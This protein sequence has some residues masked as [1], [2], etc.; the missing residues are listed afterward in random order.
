MIR[1]QIRV[2][3]ALARETGAAY[4]LVDQEHA[5]AKRLRAIAS[6]DVPDDFV[7]VRSGGM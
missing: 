7:Y 5:E 3:V 2:L 6:R 1:P 4:R